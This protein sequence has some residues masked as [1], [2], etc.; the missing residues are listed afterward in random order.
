MASLSTVSAA[1]G[2]IASKTLLGAYISF[3][4]ST[5]W[6]TDLSTFTSA[7]GQA[8]A[9]ADT[10]VDWTSWGSAMDGQAAWSAN[11]MQGLPYIPVVAIPMATAADSSADSSFRDIASGAH[12]ADF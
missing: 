7:M 10:F 9:I 11:V 2:T 12:D 4:G 5:T 1:N 8:P 6:A 3:P